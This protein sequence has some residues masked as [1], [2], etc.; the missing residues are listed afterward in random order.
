[1]ADDGG[2]TSGFHRKGNSQPISRLLPVKTAQ[3]GFS[4]RIDANISSKNRKPTGL[5][6]FRV[7]PADSC[8]ENRLPH[9]RAFVVNGKVF[10]FSKSR[11]PALSSMFEV[12]SPHGENQDAIHPAS[13]APGTVV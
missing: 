5:Q 13:F 11:L 1:M 7:I 9:S 3:K 12:N 2:Q 8:G 10:Q 4:P 6:P